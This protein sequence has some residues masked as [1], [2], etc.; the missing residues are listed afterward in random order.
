MSAISEAVWQ[1]DENI[2]AVKSSSRQSVC[3]CRY[4]FDDK[5]EDVFLYINPTNYKRRYR[6]VIYPEKV[7]VG[8]RYY[9]C[10]NLPIIKGVPQWHGLITNE[11]LLVPKGLIPPE[12][13]AVYGDRKWQI[14]LAAEKLK[15]RLRKEKCDLIFVDEKGKF[16]R[17]LVGLAECARNVSVI[18]QNTDYFF[19][20]R[21]EIYGTLGCYIE[22]NSMSAPKS[23]YEFIADGVLTDTA[24]SEFRRITVNSLC[25]QDITIPPNLLHC[26]PKEISKSALSEALY[27]AWGIGRMGDYIKNTL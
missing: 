19:G 24:K 20:L 15:K 6:K 11:K 2:R 5:G 18:T 4:F 16:G 14:L 26:F 1:H 17:V 22:V 8:N 12:N 27:S 23:G 3:G 25:D 10:L 21:E 13:F 7:E 9:F